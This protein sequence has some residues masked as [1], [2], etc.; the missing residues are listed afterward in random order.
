LNKVHKKESQKYPLE[1]SI[2]E[3]S[4]AAAPFRSILFFSLAQDHRLNDPYW[5]GNNNKF[6][7]FI[8]QPER[9]QER[10]RESA[11]C[12]NWSNGLPQ[13]HCQKN[14]PETKF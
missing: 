14:E 11:H 2:K 12:K 7:Y 6:R 8:S 10:Q 13:I 9:K 4:K 3:K 1:T 5:M